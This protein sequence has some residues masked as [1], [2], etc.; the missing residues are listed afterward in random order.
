MSLDALRPSERTVRR[1]RRLFIGVILTVL[2]GLG[3]LLLLAW[4]GLIGLDHPIVFLLVALLVVAGGV[5]FCLEA[6]RQGGRHEDG[7]WRP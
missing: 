1:L 2:L 4:M 6:L 7:W 5:E 3:I